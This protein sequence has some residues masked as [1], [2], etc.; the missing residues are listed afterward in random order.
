MPIPPWSPL[1][2][3]S[4]SVAQLPS[5]DLPLL[6]PP[7]TLRSFVLTSPSPVDPALLFLNQLLYF[8]RAWF[9]ETSLKSHETQ[10]FLRHVFWS[11]MF[12]SASIPLS[13]WNEVDGSGLDRFFFKIYTWLVVEKIKSSRLKLSSSLWYYWKMRNHY[14]SW[15]FI[16]DLSYSL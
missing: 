14:F 13:W 10:I 3:L 1:A 16:Y 4:R 5:G 12:G 7:E 6:S 15:Y 2:L 8:H 11:C 9:L